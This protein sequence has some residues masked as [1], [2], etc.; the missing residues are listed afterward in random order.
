MKCLKKSLFNRNDVEVLKIVL[1]QHHRTKINMKNRSQPII[2]HRPIPQPLITIVNVSN[3]ND[4]SIDCLH[5]NDIVLIVLVLTKSGKDLQR[6]TSTLTNVEILF[7]NEVQSSL[8]RIDDIFKQIR[9][10]IKDREVELYLQMDS[11]K[12]QGLSVIHR[13]QQRAIEL[14]HRMER[15]DRLEPADMDILRNDIKQFVTDRRYDLGEEL[16]SS[17]RF[18]YDPAMI[19][20]LKQFGHVLTVD[21]KRSIPTSSTSIEVTPT[22]NNNGQVSTNDFTQKNERTSTNNIRAKSSSNEQDLSHVL[23][24]RLNHKP[25]NTQATVVNGHVNGTQSDD[26]VFNDEPRSLDSHGEINGQHAPPIQNSSESVSYRI[27]SCSTNDTFRCRSSSSA[28]N[29][30]IK[31]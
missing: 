27:S 22:T 19:E 15:C 16:T 21:R 4:G 18:E 6:Q 20:S 7:N 12:A 26:H 3:N 29:G 9:D 25:T 14:K 30:I 17:H 13:R 28:T 8:K 11:A 2:R 31:K 24:Q 23:P 5:C 10:I 1:V